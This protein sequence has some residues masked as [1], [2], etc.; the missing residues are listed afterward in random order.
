MTRAAR[1]LSSPHLPT[2]GIFLAILICSP[3]IWHGW[4]VDDYTHQLSIVGHPDIPEFQ[5]P[6]SLL[7]DF[8]DGKPG[9]VT[10]MMEQGRLPWW[11]NPELKLSFYRPVTGFTHWLD[12]Q[13][14]PASP[15]LMHIHSLVWFALAIYLTCV[16]YRTLQFLGLTGWV[17]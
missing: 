1:W 16:L 3:S 5:R 9:T 15:A 13:L 4:Q 17:A 12:Y 14:W 7:F 6:F 11:T 10:S 2:A 8:V